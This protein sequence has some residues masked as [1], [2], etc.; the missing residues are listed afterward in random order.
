MNE[1]YSQDDLDY[2]A[3][4]EAG[5]NFIVTEVER[6]LREYPETEPVL[7]PVIRHLRNNPGKSP[8]KIIE[9]S[10]DSV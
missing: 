4:F 8:I 2:I 6:I 7:L 9:K 3:G 10:V 1:S 5:C